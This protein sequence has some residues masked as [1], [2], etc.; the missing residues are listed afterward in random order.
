MLAIAR[1]ETTA[2]GWQS[3]LDDA[4]I[5]S[6]IRIEDGVLAGRS[7]VLTQINLP[8]DNQLFAFSLWVPED[9]RTDAAHA[10]IDAGWDGQFGQRGGTIPVGF[11][12]RGALA[13]LAVA[14]AVVIIQVARS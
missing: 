7:S 3:T 1:D 6:E 5:E 8:T 2:N 13:A 11:A 10:L 12:L 14:V 9:R 4:E